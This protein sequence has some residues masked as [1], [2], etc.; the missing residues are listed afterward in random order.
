MIGGSDDRG[1]ATQLNY[2]L[3]ETNSKDPRSLS[4]TILFEIP[5]NFTRMCMKVS[6]SLE[7]VYYDFNAAMWVY[8]EMD[9]LPPKW[10]CNLVMKSIATS[11]KICI[12]IGISYGV[13]AMQVEYFMDV[14]NTILLSLWKRVIYLMYA[15]LYGVCLHC[16]AFMLVHSFSKNFHMNKTFM[17]LNIVL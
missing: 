15:N 4:K 12:D 14:L 16:F 8:L 1:C 6:T 13:L 3:R 9:Q 7:L 17:L 10:W 2:S 11:F 5:C